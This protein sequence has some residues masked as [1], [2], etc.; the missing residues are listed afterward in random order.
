MWS[1]V[2]KMA[3]FIVSTVRTVGLVLTIGFAVGCSKPEAYVECRGN[4]PTLSAGMACT[5]EHRAGSKPLRA[6][7]T[8]N[9][10]C[11]N[12]A[13]GSADGCGEV[14][15]KAKSSTV[16]PYASFH[17]ALDTCDQVTNAN[18]KT[19]KLTEL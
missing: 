18:V 14:Q 7:W 5:I 3:P 13:S 12:G 9:V 10:A 1:I 6:C 4:G 2:T 15:P 17:G 16:L 19:T 8:M 11:A